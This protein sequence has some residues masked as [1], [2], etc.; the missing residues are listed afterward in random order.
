MDVGSL[1]AGVALAVFFGFLANRLGY[2]SVHDKASRPANTSGGGSG[3][4]GNPPTH[5]K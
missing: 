4:S 2:L 3:G 5:H 1:L